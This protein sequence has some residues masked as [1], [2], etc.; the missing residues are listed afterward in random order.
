MHYIN[1]FDV[2]EIIAF[3]AV[4]LITFAPQL[5]FGADHCRDCS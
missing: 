1:K 2:N 3:D 4:I 5:A